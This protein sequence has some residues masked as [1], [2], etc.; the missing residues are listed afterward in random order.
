MKEQIKIGEDLCATEVLVAKGNPSPSLFLATSTI[1]VLLIPG[2]FS[3]CENNLVA[4]L[5]ERMFQI[6]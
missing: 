3:N 2:V 6:L 5:Q 1:I 4:Y